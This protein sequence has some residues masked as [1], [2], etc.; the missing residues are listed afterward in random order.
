MLNSLEGRILVYEVTCRYET[1][2]A[3]QNDVENTEAHKVSSQMELINDSVSNRLETSPMSW[4][5]SHLS[6]PSNS[7][8]TGCSWRC[9]SCVRNVVVLLLLHRRCRVE[10]QR[11]AHFWQPPWDTIR[12]ELRLDSTSKTCHPRQAV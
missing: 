7:P 10:Q 11:N 1:K 12:G 3:S 9:V 4:S 5:K 6:H 2:N 8:G